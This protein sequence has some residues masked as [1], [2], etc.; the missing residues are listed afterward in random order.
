MVARV[1]HAPGGLSG[2][3]TNGEGRHG[4]RLPHI[5][6]NAYRRGANPATRQKEPIAA[7]TRHAIKQTEAALSSQPMATN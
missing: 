3:M 4:A 5:F 7:A 6:G 1:Q 2:A